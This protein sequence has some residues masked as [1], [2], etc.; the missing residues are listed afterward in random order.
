MEFCMAPSRE[1]KKERLRGNENISNCLLR[2]HVCH[3]LVV[4]V[5]SSYGSYG[6][7]HCLS[8]NIA[9]CRDR[10]ELQNETSSLSEF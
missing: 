5:F 3:L 9:A 7:L 1:T 6:P 4:V 10:L 8:E 2:R